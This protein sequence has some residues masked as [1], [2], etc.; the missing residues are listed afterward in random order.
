MGQLTFPLSSTHVLPRPAPL[1]HSAGPA[2]QVMQPGSGG[3]I[4]RERE[5][6]LLVFGLH[7]DFASSSLSLDLGLNIG[8]LF[9]G[10]PD[11]FLAWVQKDRT[12]R[13]TP[14]VQ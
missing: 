6:N 2:G 13:G 3:L 12:L 8:V 1:I 14:S 5:L 4:S 9:I 11:P 10:H 7:G